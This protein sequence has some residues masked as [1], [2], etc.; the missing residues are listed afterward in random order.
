MNSTRVTRE[1]FGKWNTRFRR[2]P[3]KNDSATNRKEMVS[4]DA[5]HATIAEIEEFLLKLD[6]SERARDEWRAIVLCYHDRYG[7]GSVLS[8]HARMKPHIDCDFKKLALL[9]N[10]SRKLTDAL[11]RR[12][13]LRTDSQRVQMQRP[14]F[15]ESLLAL[16]VPNAPEYGSGLN[17]LLSSIFHP[18]DGVDGFR[19][20]PEQFD[21]VPFRLPKPA[22]PRIPRVGA[23][24]P[25]VVLNHLIEDVY[26]VR[27]RQP[28]K[29]FDG[30]IGFVERLDL[31]DGS[32]WALFGHL[33]ETY[34]RDCEFECLVPKVAVGKQVVLWKTWHTTTGE[35][36]S[37]NITTFIDYVPQTYLSAGLI[38]WYRYHL[39]HAP[40]DPGAGSSRGSW[41]MLTAAMKNGTPLGLS[42]EAMAQW[43]QWEPHAPALTTEQ[44]MLFETRGF[45]VV[46]IPD[47]VQRACPAEVSLSNFDTFFRAISGDSTFVCTD[48]PSLV[49]S[50]KLAEA[51]RS[52]ERLRYFVSK[53]DP[54]RPLDPLASGG[55][56][57]FAMKG[58]KLIAA[59]SGLGPGS[60]FTNEPVHLAFQLSEFSKSI[61]ASFYK[62]EPIVC[63]LERFRLKTATQWK[64]AWHV[65][66]AV[67]LAPGIHTPH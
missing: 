2:V 9:M 36:T 6:C 47:D 62:R 17:A 64:A 45:L 30:C 55:K 42:D 3:L 19:H 10:Q 12:L 41:Q 27:A 24:F 14:L 15:G 66:T 29:Y 26:L 35:G 61:M 40:T 8:S 65:D 43:E 46:D 38:A 56:A 53:M 31:Y 33:P 16:I 34:G 13:A 21:S 49:R 11:R 5:V 23:S 50:E 18:N 1:S 59:E 7:S 39:R 60:T 63:V 44:L 67:K 58:G 20:T 54:D 4:L 22:Q 52:G 57:T 37:C 51:E 48:P 28:P 25:A 32:R